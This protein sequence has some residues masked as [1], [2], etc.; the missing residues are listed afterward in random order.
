MLTASPNLISLKLKFSYH[1]PQFSMIFPDTVL[2]SFGDQL[3]L[4]S[5]RTF[6]LR[7]IFRYDWGNLFISSNSSTSVLRAFFARRP[8][9]QDL[10][11]DPNDCRSYLNELQPEVFPMLLPSLSILKDLHSYAGSSRAHLWP[12][13]SRVYM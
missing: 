4:T 3:T 7:G 11:L 1:D 10:V 2:A 6:H 9:I 12:N 5:L 13:N 8:R